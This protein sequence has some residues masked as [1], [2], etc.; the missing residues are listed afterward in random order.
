M[1]NSQKWHE[2]DTDE[3][4]AGTQDIFPSFHV[5]GHLFSPKRL[6]QQT[7]FSHFAEANEPDEVNVAG[8][9]RG[10]PLSYGRGY[11]AAIIRPPDTIPSDERLNWMVEKILTWHTRKFCTDQGI[12]EAVMYVNC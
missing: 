9:F 4:N 2:P 8:P 7:G 12:S 5:W 6:I 10:R 3:L 11:G 1:R